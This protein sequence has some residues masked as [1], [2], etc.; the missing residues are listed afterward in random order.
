MAA[1][2]YS[3][4]DH[5]LLKKTVSSKLRRYVPI[6]FAVTVGLT[7]SFAVFSDL[8]KTQRAKIEA[9]FTRLSDNQIA[10][11]QHTID[12]NINALHDLA[13]FY[14]ASNKISRQEFK[15]FTDSI[16]SS[17]LRK[18]S[19]QALEWI[20]RIAHRQRKA[21]EETAKNDGLE[22]FEITKKTPDGRIVTSEHRDEYYPV[23]FVEPYKGNEPAVGYD[24][25]SNPARLAAIE[26]AR[27][28]GQM[29]ATTPIRLVQETEKQAGVLI[30]KPVYQHDAPTNTIDQRREHL[31]GFVLG[32]YRMSNLLQTALGFTKSTDSID[33]QIIDKFAS[34]SESLLASL[35]HRPQPVLKDT[36]QLEHHVAINVAGR[37]WK[38]IC[39]APNGFIQARTPWDTW[40]LLIIGVAFTGGVVI[41]LLI[42]QDRTEQV[43][44]LVHTRT[45]DLTNAYEEQAK[46]AEQLAHE[47]AERKQVLTTLRENEERYQLAIQGTS[48]GLWDWNIITNEV[49]YAPKFKELLGYSGDDE[50]PHTFESF[51]SRLHPDDHD[52]T[53]KA[54]D[55]H[56]KI[57]RPFDI[58]NRLQTKDGEYRW[59]RARGLAQRDA[60]NKPMR[61]A[62]SI[63]DVTEQKL[64]EKELGKFASNLWKIK[65]EL[66]IS[67]Q[68]FDLAVRG[69]SDGLWDWP[70]TNEDAQWWSPKFY[71][72]LGYDDQEIEPEFTTLTSLLHP[73]DKDR[74]TNALRAHL[75]R[76]QPFDVEYR[77]K[78]KSGDYLWYRSRGEAT[79]DEE[80]N[81]L[82]MAGSLQ[83]I[84]TRKLAQQQLVEHAGRLKQLTEDLKEKNEELDEFA[85]I[86][87]HDLQEPL[88]KLISFS[89]LLRKDL[90]ETLN[91]RAERDLQHII[92]AAVR[93][94]TLVQ[95]LLD[96]SR[97]GRAALKMKKT[98]LDACAHDA[99]DTL[100]QR[101][102]DTKA[103]ITQDNLPEV[104]G[105]QTL[106]T[107]LYQN[108]IG[109][110]IK[111]CQKKPEIRLTVETNN[112]QTIFGVCDN[113][114][115]IKP[116]Y[117]KQVFAPFKRLHGRGE[118][119][120]TGIG[121]AICH[122]IVERHGGKIWVESQP[123]NGSHFK[124]T[125]GGKKR[126]KQ[127]QPYEQR[128]EAA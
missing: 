26:A 108:L 80:G 113:G 94:R 34:S 99:L 36:P 1:P 52:Q 68:R 64:A 14:D 30:F 57:E 96:L 31:L 103:M 50:F 33:I 105:D 23:Y 21:H 2:T 7:L 77:L 51:E 43:E 115:G 117:A 72:L 39:T 118:Y 86:A 67:E 116:E 79:R 63:Q 20:P 9:E 59:F 90:D 109:N 76:S 78:S 95:D 55:K 29:V 16:L 53:L 3:D 111:Y 119:E 125:I 73:E 46:I 37:Q 97:T 70:D 38:I 45:A 91:E 35:S 12:E 124:F 102:T 17:R 42:L 24:L 89:E 83:N 100:A 121:L 65:E 4:H 88:R 40:A 75:D 27:D 82:R 22:S 122:K 104:R 32:V 69:A 62:G 18:D 101:I 98:P 84:N 13:A 106:L 85:H 110:A 127:Q 5:P 60:D 8:R 114:I 123:L 126:T 47:T 56:L 93:M 11:V 81:P 61:M 74:T 112:G 25:A 66:R 58:D 92:Q 54:I 6:V 71:G 128:K 41:Y 44:Q 107:Q 28:S 19:I 48:D 87:S 15:T 10:M 120:G 49:W